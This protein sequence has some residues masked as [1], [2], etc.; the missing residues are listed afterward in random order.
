MVSACGGHSIPHNSIELLIRELNRNLTLFAVCGFNPLPMQGRGRYAVEPGSAQVVI[1]PLPRRPAPGSSN[2]F[3]FLSNV[4]KLEKER[5]LISKMI[6][7][8]S[9]ELMRLCP[10]FGENLGYDGKAVRSNSTGLVSRQ[11]GMTSDPEADWGR[12]ET[13]GVDFTVGR[14]EKMRSLASGCWERVE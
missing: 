4:V 9:E 6:E 10:D 8:R 7:S 5:G 2:F 1:N 13:S 3:R 14:P 11:T 12:H